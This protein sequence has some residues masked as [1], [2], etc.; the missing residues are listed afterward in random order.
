MSGNPRLN[1]ARREWKRAGE[2]RRST[3]VLKW[4][5][6]P[7]FHDEVQTEDETNELQVTEKSQMHRL[8]FCVAVT[9]VRAVIW[10]R[11]AAVPST[12]DGETRLRVS[13]KK[14]QK[15]ES[16]EFFLVWETLIH[17]RG[18][19]LQPSFPAAHHT[20]FAALASGFVS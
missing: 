19:P 5:R 17:L 20:R 9:T 12:S 15:L 13:A 7:H 4:R 6:F 11:L 10:A 18:R 14:A 8:L 3:E 2:I 16:V 1:G